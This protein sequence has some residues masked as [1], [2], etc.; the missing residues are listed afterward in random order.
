MAH[1]EGTPRQHEAHR[2]RFT[3]FPGQAPAGTIPRVETPAP[4]DATPLTPLTPDTPLTPLTPL[5][6]DAITEAPAA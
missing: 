2:L 6:P 5:T 4:P 1:T 3:R